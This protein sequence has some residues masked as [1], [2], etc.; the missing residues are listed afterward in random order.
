MSGKNTEYLL[1]VNQS[2]FDRLQFQHSVWRSNT[3][4]FFDRIG[5]GKG[6]HCLDVGAGPGFVSFELRDRVGETGSITAL[7][8]STM[9]LEWFAEQVK[10]QQWKNV[11]V[12][13][14][15]AEE[16]GLPEQKYD[17]IFVRW[18]IA[19]V[20]QPEKFL[21]QLLSAL[22]PNGIIAI[23]DYYYEGLSVYPR[24]G[25]FDG[26][27]DIVRAYYDTVN[28]DPYI[29]GKIPSWFKKYNLQTIDYSPHSYAGGPESP[30]M[31]WGHRFFSTHIQHMVDKQLMTQSQGDAMLADWIAHRNNPDALFF[32]PIVVDVAGR[33]L[34]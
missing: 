20:A 13:N 34:K 30:I 14:G 26:M 6:W 27:A 4:A 10:Q 31:E 8:P 25:A 5:V 3:N 11:H 32:S 28:G 23:Q 18:V 16:T 24:G 7:E 22:K 21:T 9:F 12:V 1:G 17:L 19:F 15:T 2:E 29:T 33:K